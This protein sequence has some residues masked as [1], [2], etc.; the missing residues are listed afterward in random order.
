[1]KGGGFCFPFFF[2]GFVLGYYQAG[3][4]H[5]NINSA[6]QAYASSFPIPSGAGLYVSK[7]F[8]PLAVSGVAPNV[9]SGMYRL[10]FFHVGVGTFTYF[11]TVGISPPV[12]P[13][14]DPLQAFNSGLYF[15]S[16]VAVS[17]LTISVFALLRRA[18]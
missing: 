7:T 17:F 8:D 16:I 6:Y 9:V 11:N 5:E 10:D 3:L 15:G 1:M 12:F 13:V 14:C 4:C 2:G 18:L